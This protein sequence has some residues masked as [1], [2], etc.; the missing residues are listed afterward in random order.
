MAALLEGW[1]VLLFFC[2]LQ[3]LTYF[4]RGVMSGLLSYAEAKWEINGVESGLL[5]SSYFISVMIVAPVVAGA[6]VNASGRFQMYAIALGALLWILAAACC[7][8]A[9]SYSMLLMGRIMTGLGETFYCVLASPIISDCAP[10]RSRSFYLGV[11]Y[12]L[13]YVATGVG[14][15]AP[16]FSRA[17]DGGCLVFLAEAAL[18]LPLLLFAILAADRFHGTCSNRIDLTMMGEDISITSGRCDKP[19]HSCMHALKQTWRVFC[20]RRFLLFFLGYSASVFSLNGWNFWGPTYMEEVLHVKKSQGTLML[21]GA[22]VL[23]GI[24]GSAVGG[25][26]LDRISGRGASSARQCR[27]AAKIC[28]LSAAISLPFSAVATASKDPWTTTGLAAGYMFFA[29]IAAAPC[30][31]GMMAAVPLECRGIAMGLASFGSHIFGDVLS[32]FVVG[33][34]KDWKGSLVPGM[35]LLVL[36][37]LLPMFFWGL[38]SLSSLGLPTSTSVLNRGELAAMDQVS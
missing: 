28:C 9:Q 6:L 7:G 36:W 18:M 8:L 13:V 15:V 23:A 19:C 2:Y 3:F 20:D 1:I 33:L 26:A 38:A 29:T 22:V 11:F 30:V 17:W 27:V 31:V 24:S 10:P 35:W 37:I 32:P 25:F 4:D 12:A 16:S 21:G 14:F 34:L 5:G